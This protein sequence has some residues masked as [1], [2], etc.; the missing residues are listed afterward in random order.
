MTLFGGP[1]SFCL[2]SSYVYVVLLVAMVVQLQGLDFLVVD[3]SVVDCLVVGLQR[4]VD[5][6]WV[7]R[8][9]SE[10]GCV[11]GGFCTED[12]DA[13]VSSADGLGK[14][15]SSAYGSGAGSGLGSGGGDGEWSGVIGVVGIWLGVGC[16]TCGGESSGMSEN[17]LSI[18][19]LIYSRFSSSTSLASSLANGGCGISAGIKDEV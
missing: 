2:S 15:G 17:R 19:R 18:T 12:S 5:S 6:R 13:N 10:A 11:S 1:Y 16:L 7:S 3:F 14:G 8:M 9:S 4:S